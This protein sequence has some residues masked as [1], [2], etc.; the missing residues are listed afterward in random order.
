[1]NMKILL[2][3]EES[4]YSREA[5]RILQQQ[6]RIENAEI[7]VLSV[8]EPISVYIS[9]DMLPHFTPQAEA[10]EEDRRKQ[11]MDLVSQVAKELRGAGFQATESIDLGDAK[12]KI[13]ENATDWQ[14]DLIVMGSHGWKGLNRFLLGSVSDAVARHAPCSV[15]I[16]RLKPAP[17]ITKAKQEGF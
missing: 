2:A 6:F 1:V 3:I 10:I 15:E 11:A 9:A 13:I 14:A 17:A 5:I 16:V 12:T 4:H 7:R 8:V